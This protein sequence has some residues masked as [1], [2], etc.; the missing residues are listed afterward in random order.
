M[1]QAYPRRLIEV[2]LPIKRI[3]SQAR[4]IFAI[5]KTKNPAAKAY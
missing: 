4:R 2:D 5:R 1:A 3:F